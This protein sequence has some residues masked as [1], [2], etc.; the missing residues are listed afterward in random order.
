MNDE[1]LEVENEDHTLEE[2]VDDTVASNEEKDDDEDDEVGEEEEEDDEEEDPKLAISSSAVP[3]AVPSYQTVAKLPSP[4]AVPAVV[5]SVI[6]EPVSSSSSSS[7]GDPAEPAH[8]TPHPRLLP[9]PVA[10][11][12]AVVQRLDKQESSSSVADPGHGSPAD[13]R[14]RPQHQP[15]KCP[16]PNPLQQVDYGGGAGYP[17]APDATKVTA[18]SA[19]P[20]SPAYARPPPAGGVFKTMVAHPPRAAGDMGFAAAV[21]VPPPYRTP[22][23]KMAGPPAYLPPQ[24][25]PPQQIYQ[26][27]TSTAPP[28]SQPPSVGYSPYPIDYAGTGASLPPPPPLIPFRNVV[29]A[30]P[31]H[32]HA[33]LPPGTTHPQQQ[34]VAGEVSEFGGLVSYFSSQQEDDFDT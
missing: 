25:Q 32:E 22:A 19:V 14:K 27:P 17:Y 30:P 4:S 29:V 31:V 6:R 10:A 23:N 34:S 7:S 16:S 18:V 15:K 20:P 12:A 33:L 11:A 13:K 26:A 28:P 3:A 21:P 9:P 8:Y 2:E 5:Q 1:E 24:V